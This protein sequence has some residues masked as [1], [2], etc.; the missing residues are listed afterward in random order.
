MKTVPNILNNTWISADLSSVVKETDNNNKNKGKTGV[1]MSL[2]PVTILHTFRIVQFESEV[3]SYNHAKAQTIKGSLYGTRGHPTPQTHLHTSFLRGG[4][5]IK[6]V[7]SK[8][9][10]LLFLG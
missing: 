7:I 1:R 3:K 9:K 4:I 8:F 5:P 2:H 6:R 10:P